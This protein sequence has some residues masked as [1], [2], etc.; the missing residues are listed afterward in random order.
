M[1][2]KMGWA[3]LVAAFA[4][5]LVG[6][7]VAEDNEA[8]DAQ[9]SSVS[10]DAI[11]E[12]L[13]A[14]LAAQRGDINGALAVYQRLARELRDPQI[15]RRAVEAAIR[16]RAFPEALDSATLLLELEPESTLAREIMATLLA[17]EG[18]LAK[19]RDTMA[20]VLEKNANRGPLLMQLSH[21]FG[22]FQDKAAV[23]EA[24]RAIASAYDIPEA[25]YAIGVAA[26][27]A[28]KV[29][30]ATGEADAA[31]VLNPSWQQGAI[32][33]AQVLR[34]T[35]PADIIPYYQS[36]VAANPESLNDPAGLASIVREIGVRWKQGRYS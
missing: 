31:L 10:T 12:Y 7:A 3:G 26:L 19:A 9:Y 14:E 32:L 17:N 11:Y 6:P 13:V 15:A 22:K 23:L 33:R 18:D 20:R 27:V 1:T 35:A 34:K 29:D 8:A 2:R 16:A 5:G 24:T 21:L 30:L 4:L 36:F 28:G 25:H